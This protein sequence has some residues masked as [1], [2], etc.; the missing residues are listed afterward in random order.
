[1]G[2]V[3]DIVDRSLGQTLFFFETD[4]GQSYLVNALVLLDNLA[5]LF[6]LTLRHLIVCHDVHRGGGLTLLSILFVDRLVDP[7]LSK[8]TLR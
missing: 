8:K 1:M 3:E 2:E 5:L 4:T 6:N 7:F